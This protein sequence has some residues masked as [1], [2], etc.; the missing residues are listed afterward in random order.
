MRTGTW[1]VKVIGRHPVL[2]LHY[3]GAEKYLYLIGQMEWN[4]L[5]LVD[6]ER[7]EQLPVK[8]ISN[9]VVHQ[10]MYNDPFHP[11]NNQWRITPPKAESDS[12]IRARVKQC[13][14]FYALYFRDN[15]KRQAKTIDFGGLPAIFEWYNRGI[16]LPN[17]KKVD[18]SWVRCFY[19][20]EQA[21][22]GYDLLRNLIV[23]Y[24]FNWPDG[25]PS[26]VYETHSVLEQ[27]Y[28]KL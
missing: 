15:I 3:T 25:A 24:E 1:R 16:G 9:G 14:R 10:N 8:L 21:L 22:K 23:D 17:R 7:K 5:V 11:A 20:R 28:H 26:W 27:M 6:L 13:V 18:D 4:R 2:E 19:N 12:A